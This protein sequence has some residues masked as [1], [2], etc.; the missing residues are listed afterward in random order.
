MSETD[1]DMVGTMFLGTTFLEIKWHCLLHDGSS[2]S[3]VF[4]NLLQVSTSTQL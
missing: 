3:V 4:Q 1:Q 2:D